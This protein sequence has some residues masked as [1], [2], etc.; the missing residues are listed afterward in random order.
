MQI[1]VTARHFT[2]PP[3]LKDL[4]EKEINKL[5]R[6]FDGVLACHVILS[7]ENGYDMAEIIAR[8]KKHQFT[9]IEQDP[10]IERAVTSA[11]AKFK[12]QVKRYK[13]KLVSKP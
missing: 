12:T 2:A 8:S 1:D 9:V 5:G 6:Y 11:L 4:I 13:D 10:K 7:R 3:Q